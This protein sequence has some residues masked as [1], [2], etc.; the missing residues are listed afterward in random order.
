MG[1]DVVYGCDLSNRTRRA[2]YCPKDNIPDRHRGR[3]TGR[4]KS[5]GGSRR[6]V[7]VCSGT[8]VKPVRL[9]TVINRGVL[10]VYCLVHFRS[11]DTR[12]V[13]SP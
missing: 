2:S 5:F 8:L 1:L 12:L 4:Q 10:D 7:S 3:V 11:V 13:R 6:S 9:N